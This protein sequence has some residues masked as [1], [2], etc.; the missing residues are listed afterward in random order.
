MSFAKLALL[1]GAV[2]VAASATQAQGPGPLDRLLGGP[3]A[4]AAPNEPPAA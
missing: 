1:S 2:L 4:P 3:A